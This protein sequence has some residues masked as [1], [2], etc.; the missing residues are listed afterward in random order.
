MEDWTTE[1][2]MAEDWM[3]EDWMA[4]DWTAEDWTAEDWTAEETEHAHHTSLRTHRLQRLK[5]VEQ[6]ICMYYA[7]IQ[8]CL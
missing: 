3:A 5:I 8:L 6:V 7:F 2:W 1:D 4:E